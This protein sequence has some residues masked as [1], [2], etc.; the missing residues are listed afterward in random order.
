MSPEQALGGNVEARS[1]LYG[2]GAT[3]YYALSGQIPFDGQSATEIL[4]KHVTEAPPALA[5]LGLSVPRKLASVID[6][7]LSK[8]PEHRPSTA[9]TLAEQLGV[10]LEQRRELP[11]ALRAFVKRDCRLNGGGTLIAGFALL[12]AASGMAWLF[13]NQAGYVTFALGL[14]VAPLGYLVYVARRLSALGFS[15]HDVGP[16]F[17]AEM[18]Q[19]REELA[20]ARRN[21][22]TRLEKVCAGIA[23][24]SAGFA[25][26]GAA[27]LAASAL[28]GGKALLEIAVQVFVPSN[29]IAMISTL[30]MI[31]LR[32]RHR[33]VDTEFWSKIW[34]GRIG[35]VVFGVARKLLGRRAPQSAMTHR[36]T[37][38]SLRM[39]AEE[40]FDSLPS[41][42]QRALGDLPVILRRLQDDAQA[43]RTRY[44]D[45]QEALSNAGTSA[46]SAEL[47]DVRAT[48]DSIHAKLGEAVGALET[49]RLNLLRLHAGSATIDGLTTHLGFAAEVS[50]QLARLIAAH[51]EVEQTIKIPLRSRATA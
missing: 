22:S 3:A 9:Q 10:A 14:T 25:A 29:G 30:A 39:A 42:T 17:R 28:F 20:V 49:I 33:D 51:E 40:L 19:A 46:S 2:L 12:P 15:P 23:K 26:L 1:D 50:D 36:A 45:L 38:L 11:A 47:D 35:K 16:A 5:S 32:Q 43:L 24:V 18:E 41:E 8:D 37:E 6:R 34:T 48:R 44:D 31:A 7:C 27:G 4:A 13:G 21:V